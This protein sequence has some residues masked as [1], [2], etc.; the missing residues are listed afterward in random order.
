MVHANRPWKIFSSFKKVI[1]IAFATGSYGLIFPSLWNLSVVFEPIRYVILMITALCSMVLWII[2]A[3]NLWE[4]PA[5]WN[6]KKMR[7]LY[8]MTT[9]LT[10]SIAVILYYL[11]LF[12]LFFFSVRL[13]VPDQL[14]D[15][16]SVLKGTI[17]LKNYLEL[18]WLVTSVATLG[19]A[20]GAGLE[21]DELVSSATY[22]YRQQKRYVS[23]TV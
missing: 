10:L 6:K 18:I 11:I 1:A 19:G 23:T 14:F 8:N 13:F 4:R 3:H 20:I 17:T 7:R 15:S 22:G 2:L 21:N 5:Y 16:Q 9:I 12:V